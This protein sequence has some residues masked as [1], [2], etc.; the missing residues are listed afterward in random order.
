MKIL[1]IDS[2]AM[3]MQLVKSK[4]YEAGHQVV[5]ESVKNDAIEKL[6]HEDFDVVLIDPA[7]LTNARP[8]VLGIHRTSRNYPYVV[9]VSQSIDIEEA[10]KSGANDFISKPIDSE[11]LKGCLANATRLANI[12]RRIGDDSED[13]PSAGG[14]IAKSAFNQLILSGIDRADRYGE[15]S[16]LVFIGIENYHEMLELDGVYAAEYASAKLSQYLVRIRRQ[17]DIIAQTGRG[18]YCL[19]LQRPQY[20]SEPLD[21][22]NRFAEA[23]AES[24]EVFAGEVSNASVYINLVDLPVG[25]LHMEQV[26]QNSFKK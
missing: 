20:E 25:G 4:L 19:L 5:E 11:R 10:K 14:V 21:A 22:A 9:L 18:E 15:V 16:F 13:F 23:L 3:A 1:I 2:D 24:E 8:L 26:I 12:V 7:P 6:Q 17:S